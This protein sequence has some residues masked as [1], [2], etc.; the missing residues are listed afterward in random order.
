MLPLPHYHV[1]IENLRGIRY[2]T[3]YVLISSILGS[4]H[5]HLKRRGLQKSTE[6]LTILIPLVEL[7]NFIHI[8]FLPLIEREREREKRMCIISLQY[9]KLIKAYQVGLA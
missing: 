7:P 5:E 2:V 1:I 6:I 4:I 8:P 3:F 9:S